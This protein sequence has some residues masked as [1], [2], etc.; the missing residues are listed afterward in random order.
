MKRQTVVDAFDDDNVRRIIQRHGS[1]V[2]FM[3]KSDHSIIYADTKAE[4][5][6]SLEYWPSNDALDV[7]KTRYGWDLPLHSPSAFGNALHRKLYP[8]LWS[9]S[10]MGSDGYAAVTARNALYGGRCEAIRRT[11]DE[12]VALFEYDI[13]MAYPHA[14]STIPLPDPHSGVYVHRGTLGNIRDYEGVSEIQFS[15]DGD[16]PYLPFR[17][18]DGIV[19]AV[20]ERCVG[21]YT[22]TELRSALA[23]GAIEIHGVGKQY[24]YKTL[25]VSPYA[26]IMRLFSQ[27]RKDDNNK[28]W[29]AVANATIGR[30]ASTN[31][32]HLIRFRHTRRIR[33][34]YETPNALK[35]EMGG[36]ALVAD[37]V[38]VSFKPR[39]GALHSAYILASVRNTITNAA[40]KYDAAYYDTDCIFVE[41]R[42]DGLDVGSDMGQW[43]EIYGSFNIAGPKLYARDSEG[44]LKLVQSGVKKVNQSMVS[45]HAARGTQDRKKLE[46]GSTAPHEIEQQT[47]IEQFALFDSSEYIVAVR[48]DKPNR[49]YRKRKS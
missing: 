24:I 44:V 43:K 37:V 25:D 27:H 8:D 19:Y 30:L 6:I 42:I 36:Y 49:S 21:W 14:A 46:D 23:I 5:Y 1:D 13:N 31:T 18:K 15:Q 38:P 20:A 10:R 22:H 39:T 48:S 41:D 33:E 7:I 16:I 40:I 12:F 26:D 32:S 29:K 11:N 3:A 45:F 34:I 28:V 9:K 35:T 47:A 4:R 17:E 2:S